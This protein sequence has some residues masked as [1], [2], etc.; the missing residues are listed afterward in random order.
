MTSSS[1][2]SSVATRTWPSGVRSRS[3]WSSGKRTGRPTSS[4]SV[5]SG[6]AGIGTGPRTAQAT[7]PSS[8]GSWRGSRRWSR[9][10]SL[11]PSRSEPRAGRWP[12]VLARTAW[13]R[14]RHRS[15]PRSAERM[16][17]PGQGTRGP[18]PVWR[19]CVSWPGLP[20]GQPGGHTPLSG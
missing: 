3:G 20:G 11:A 4:D 10:P 13:P 15:R 6:L 7:R 14:S 12:Q 19:G 5:T 2:G 1:C 9:T 16:T 8:P 17:S 18:G